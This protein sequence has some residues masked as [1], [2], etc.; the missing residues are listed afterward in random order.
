MES[1]ICDCG[2]VDINGAKCFLVPPLYQNKVLSEHEPVIVQR[3]E[4]SQL[5]WESAELN[6]KVTVIISYLAL[7]KLPLVTK[8]V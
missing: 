5:L 2:Y 6:H 7:S 1:L 8:N 4:M 3:I